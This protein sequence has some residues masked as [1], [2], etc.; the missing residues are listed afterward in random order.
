MTAAEEN[1][2]KTYEKDD[3]LNRDPI[4]GE[5]G[6]HPVGTGVGALGAGAA[7]AA[8]GAL[9]GPVGAAVGGVIGIVVGA[10]AGHGVAEGVNPTA[11]RAYW[12]DAYLSEP[13]FE[14]GDLFE[15]Y[16]PAYQLG[17]AR[18]HLYQGQTFDDAE[19]DLK[20]EWEESKGDSTLTWDKAKLAAK[21]SWD[22]IDRGSDRERAE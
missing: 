18:Y 19:T 10:A 20:D 7:G 21:A 5:P 9:G 8:I 13:Y 16:D 4:T 12:R 11:E 3:Q 17:Y 6:S 15:D 1:P 14:E 2:M 22:R